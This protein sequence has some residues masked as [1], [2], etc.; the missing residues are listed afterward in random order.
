MV[1][2]TA[3]PNGRG[4]RHDVDPAKHAE[5]P[6]YAGVSRVS[7]DGSNWSVV[8]PYT[9]DGPLSG[10]IVHVARISTSPQD[11]VLLL[12]LPLQDGIQGRAMVSADGGNFRTWPEQGQ[13]APPGILQDVAFTP[14]GAVVG[15]RC[16][17]QGAASQSAVVELNRDGSGERMIVA[18]SAGHVARSPSVS[19]DGSTIAFADDNGV[20][21]R[22]CFSLHAPAAMQW[23]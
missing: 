1:V 8:L 21:R 9:G 5:D 16:M 11:G 19:P 20:T 4:E 15:V 3:W 23:H 13:S 6:A 17:C 12:N 10:G 18:P 14:D 2:V 7:T 22:H